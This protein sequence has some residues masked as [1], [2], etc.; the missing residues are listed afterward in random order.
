MLCRVPVSAARLTLPLCAVEEQVYSP[1]DG[2]CLFAPAQTSFAR[3]SPPFWP[4]QSH[5]GALTPGAPRTAGLGGTESSVAVKE[6]QA[7]AGAIAGKASG[8]AWAVGT[9]CAGV[10]ARAR[11]PP[12]SQ[13]AAARQLP[14]RRSRARAH[15]RSASS[16]R[17]RAAASRGALRRRRLRS[18]PFLPGYRGWY[19]GVIARMARQSTRA[20]PWEA[21][22]TLVP[23]ER[24]A[25]EATG[26][27]RSVIWLPTDLPP[28]SQP[29][30]DSHPLH[31]G[32]RL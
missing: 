8:F 28:A 18:P 24:G 26:R 17:V 11:L 25:M 7:Q 9:R 16:P 29:R 5:R 14:L 15:R 10:F 2:D 1:E 22:S 32:P 30:G 21:T 4:M 12:A 27:G 20:C 19:G 13:P 6:Y 31:L 23:L 3:A